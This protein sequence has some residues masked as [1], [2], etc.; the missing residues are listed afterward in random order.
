M[1]GINKISEIIRTLLERKKYPQLREMLACMEGADI[2][3][4]FTEL[5]TEQCLVVFRLLPKEIASEAF[6]EMDADMQESLINSFTDKEITN[7]VEELYYDDTADIIEEMPANVVQRILKNALPDT[8]KAVNE[9]LKYPE[10]SAGAIMTTEYVGLRKN[11]TVDQAFDF[12]RS[13]ALDKETV[14]SCYV[15]DNRK[16]IGVVSVKM[17][18]LS[19]RDTAIEQIMD[20]N[21][22]SVRTNDD[23]EEIAAMFS[24]YNFLAMPVVDSEDRLVGII[25]VDDAMDVLQEEA[26]EDFAKMAAMTPADRPYLKMPVLKIWASRIPWLLI[27]MISATF[28]GIIITKFESALASVV[29]LT[30]VIPM[31]MDTGGN[32]GSQASVTIIRGISLGEVEFKDIFKVIF[33]EFRVSI[34]C[35]LSLAAA[36]FLKVMLVDRLLLHNEAV[37]LTVAL[38]VCLTLAATVVLAKFIGCTMPL[39]AKKI[40]FDPAVM[41]SPLITTIV[42][43]VSLLVYFGFAS[44]ILHL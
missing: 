36:A 29:A 26:E 6:V 40:G 22:I 3:E 34:L 28:T 11:L 15:T 16:L 38:V 41:A 35:G 20:T 27:L 12:I 31:L 19:P 44:W 13:V 21:I 39:L 14:Y 8:R 33:K 2:A 42:D 9:L 18:L 24:K 23:Q 30:A 7:L 37:S 43:A 25:T 1:E 4:V 17:M 10:N 5:D 32:S